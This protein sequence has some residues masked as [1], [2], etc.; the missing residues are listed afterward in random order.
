MRVYVLV[1]TIDGEACI[2]RVFVDEC[3]ARNTLSDEYEDQLFNIMNRTDNDKR[4]YSYSKDLNSARIEY[5]SNGYDVSDVWT[6]DI[7]ET[8]LEE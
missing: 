4:Y 2:P 8:E 6:W 7:F 3:Q 1:P 5:K